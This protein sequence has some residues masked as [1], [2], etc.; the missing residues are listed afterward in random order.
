MRVDDGRPALVAS[1]VERFPLGPAVAD[2][3]TDLRITPVLRRLLVH[4]RELLG[5]VA[6]SISQVELLAAPAEVPI[7][8]F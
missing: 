1:P 5:T 7:R 4:S 6:G 2:M 3:Y 8:V